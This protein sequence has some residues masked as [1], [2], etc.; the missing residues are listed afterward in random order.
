MDELLN[1]E[2]TEA[3]RKHLEQMEATRQLSAAQKLQPRLLGTPDAERVALHKRLRERFPLPWSIDNLGPIA[4]AQV[5]KIG[6]FFDPFTNN[7]RPV[8]DPCLAPNDPIMNARANSDRVKA[9][10]RYWDEARQDLKRRGL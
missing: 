9:V 7:R 2:P 8:L 10:Q 5:A 4:Y 6:Q 3:E 1:W